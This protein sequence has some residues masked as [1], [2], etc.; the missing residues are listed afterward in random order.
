MRMISHSPDETLAIGASFAEKAVPGQILA[1]KGDLG[2]GKIV[3]AK[4]FAKGLGI[5][6]VVNS[7]TFTILQVY[8]SGRLPFYHFDMYRLGEPEELEQLGYE[9]YFFSDG[10][11]LVEWPEMIGELLPE[12]ALTVEIRRG[13]DPDERVIEARMPEEDPDAEPG[14]ED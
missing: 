4:G 9:E 5:D 13:E 11:C 1:L 12:D 2:A 6:D 7:P 8:E 3:F 10:V 14:E